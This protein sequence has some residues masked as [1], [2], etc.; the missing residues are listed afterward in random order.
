MAS[1]IYGQ[2][3]E[4]EILTADPLK[5]VIILYRSAIESVGAARRHL[6]AGAIR[7]RSRQITR[8][9]EIVHELQLTLDRA[10]GGAISTS[11]AQLYAYMQNRLIEANAKQVDPPLAEVEAL[12]STLL[13]A[14]RELPG[15]QLHEGVPEYAPVS[16][17]Y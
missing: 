7:E 11:L 14:W 17:T 6:A 1:T 15:A 2:Y 5:L 4:A 3:F 16:C 9:W 10:R 8:A 12:L 13:E